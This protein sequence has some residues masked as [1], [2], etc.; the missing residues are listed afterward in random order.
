L[1]ASQ[2]NSLA[3]EHHHLVEQMH[4]QVVIS[5]E[6]FVQG[7][8]RHYMP[9]VTPFYTVPRSKQSVLPAVANVSL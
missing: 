5:I 1:I 4:E 9:K 2:G 7:Q 6:L 3:V 8:H